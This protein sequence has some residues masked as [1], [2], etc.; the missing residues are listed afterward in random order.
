MSADSNFSN[1]SP[2]GPAIYPLN[3]EMFVFAGPNGS[4]KSTVIENHLEN[5]QCP[6]IYI[7][8]D[9][10]VSREDKYNPAAYLEAMKMAEDFRHQ[11]LEAGVSFTFETV[12]S[13]AD[14]LDFLRTAKTFGYRITTIYITTSDPQ[15]NLNRIAER[16][17]MG[18]HDVPK[19]K[20]LARYEKSMTLMPEVI[21]LSDMA[22]VYDNSSNC[23]VEVFEK[24]DCGNFFLLNREQRHS[25]VDK[26]ITTAFAEKE[27]PIFE[28][29]NVFE[30]ERLKGF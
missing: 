16:V 3:K 18:G 30:T 28:D 14:K 2:T 24:D 13:T 19:D 23:P 12:F 25:W 5:K 22:K 6:E 1:S 29:L 17:K 4:G 7:C 21:L 9:Q 15:I 20:V 8:P 26:Y 11:A 10:L 27:I